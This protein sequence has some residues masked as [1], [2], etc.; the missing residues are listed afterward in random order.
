[1]I[2]KTF[3]VIWATKFDMH[4]SKP[5]LLS[6][7]LHLFSK[8]SEGD[9]EEER[10]EQ[11]LEFA[12]SFF[13]RKGLITDTKTVLDLVKDF[14]DN[15]GEALFTHWIFQFCYPDQRTLG[16]YF[17]QQHTMNPRFLLPC[18]GKASNLYDCLSVNGWAYMHPNS[19]RS[20]ELATFLGCR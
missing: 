16:T 7:L 13:T 2:S 11:N 17:Y 18:S 6:L 8:T 19:E 15:Y 5:E 10:R 4:L 12:K 14:Y 3:A 9:D 20:D 1:M